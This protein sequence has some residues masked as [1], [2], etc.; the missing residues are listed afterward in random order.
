MIDK[1]NN[2]NNYE[3]LDESQQENKRREAWKATSGFGKGWLLMHLRQDC[4]TFRY[5]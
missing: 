1:G 3:N 2:I 5:I 4:F